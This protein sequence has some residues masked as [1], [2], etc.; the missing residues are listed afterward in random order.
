MGSPVSSIVANL[1]ME[2]FEGK[3]LRSATNPPQVWYRVWMTHQSSNDSPVNR[4]SWNTSIA[5]IQ[6]SS[7]WWKVLKEMG[8]YPSLIP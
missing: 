2:H 5:L 1:Y 4:H 3:A 6:Q 8:L 7:L